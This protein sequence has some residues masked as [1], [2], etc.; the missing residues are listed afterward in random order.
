MGNIVVVLFSNEALEFITDTSEIARAE[1]KLRDIHAKLVPGSSALVVDVDE[2]S[3]LT[4][5][6]RVQQLGGEIVSP[7]MMRDSGQSA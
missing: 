2:G 4:F 7:R 3:L 6:A 1:Q 5:S